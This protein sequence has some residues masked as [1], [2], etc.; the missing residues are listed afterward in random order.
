M[1]ATNLLV[2]TRGAPPFAVLP[3]N[4]GSAGCDSGQ[5]PN[6]ISDGELDSG[7][8]HEFAEMITD[9]YDL[10]RSELAR[11]TF[12]AAFASGGPA[13]ASDPAHRPPREGM[14]SSL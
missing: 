4:V 2:A 14:R 3:Y 9:P 6:G 13:G 1:S 8:V 11:R 7:M 12:R 10:S 5:H